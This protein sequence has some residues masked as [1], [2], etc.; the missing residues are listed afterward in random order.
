MKYL[1]T[2]EAWKHRDEILYKNEDFTISLNDKGNMTY[3]TNYLSCSPI[4]GMIEQIRKKSKYL[5]DHKLR[6][7]K[8]TYQEKEF[9]MLSIDPFF[10]KNRL[11]FRT[12]IINNF[13]GDNKDE[14]E[15]IPDNV[16]VYLNEIYF[17]IIDDIINKSETIGDIIDYFIVLYDEITEKLPLFLTTSKFNI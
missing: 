15:R 3:F 17:P 8:L 5:N 11:K 12:S 10:S 13:I 6:N 4:Y 2:I 16:Y 14:I 7:I 9:A 1:K